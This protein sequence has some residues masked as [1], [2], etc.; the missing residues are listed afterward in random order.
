MQREASNIISYFKYTEHLIEILSRCIMAISVYL[1]ILVTICVYAFVSGTFFFLTSLAMIK[2]YNRKNC[3]TCL[4][5]KFRYGT[6]L[7]KKK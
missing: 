1:K 6:N 7:K 4:A 2:E 3:N 5:F